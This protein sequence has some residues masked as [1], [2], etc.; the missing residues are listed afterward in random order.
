MEHPW[1][2]KFTWT[3]IPQPARPPPRDGDRRGPPSLRKHTAPESP[4]GTSF[5]E[6]LLRRRRECNELQECV[7]ELVVKNPPA[8]QE[9]QETRVRSLNPEDPLE[10]GTATHSG[11][12]A[13][14]I[15]M[16]RGA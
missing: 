6:D 15:P 9:T 2:R 10:E 8:A 5:L 4:A 16:D 13:W 12:L 1:P 11:I 7:A 14:R 3:Q